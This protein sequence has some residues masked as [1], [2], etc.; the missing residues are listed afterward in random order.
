MIRIDRGPEPAALATRRTTQLKT[1]GA[2]KPARTDAHRT[3]YTSVKKE[4]AIAQHRKCC[5][6]ERIE[7]QDFNDVEHYRPFARYWW[8]AWTWE[9]LLFA[10]AT[11]NRSG[12]KAAFPLEDGSAALVFGQQPPGA[13]RPLLVDP[14]AEDPRQHI[15]FECVNG[16]WLPI[17]RTPR[18]RKTLEILAFD[19][20]YHDDVRRHVQATMERVRAW[21]LNAATSTPAA[22]MWEDLILTLLAPSRAFGA[23]TEDVLRHELPGFRDP[24][25]R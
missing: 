12:K 2:S 6:C 5:Y 8:L 17:G 7:T 25:Q 20:D 3:A 21:R 19:D 23:L 9:N 22:A 14:A 11:C 1:V 18:G 15:G 16:K 10:C 13:E 24:S 4:L